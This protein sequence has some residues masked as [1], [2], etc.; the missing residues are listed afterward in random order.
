MLVLAFDHLSDVHEITIPPSAQERKIEVMFVRGGDK[1]RIGYEAD[2]QIE[3]VRRKVRQRGATRLAS[4]P[5]GPRLSTLDPRPS[6]LD[7]CDS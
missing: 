3:I 5:S 7:S 1:P 4:D 6:T 2:R